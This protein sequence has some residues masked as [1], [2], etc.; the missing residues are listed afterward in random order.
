[1]RNIVLPQDLNFAAQVIVWTFHELVF[2]RLLVAV[3][4]LPLDLLAAFVVT[5]NDFIET[6]L[7]MR[8]KVL[9][10]DDGRAFLVR[11]INPPVGADH[12]V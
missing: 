6:S 8:V 1:M 2:T 12:L 9:I 4:V 5:I 10:D 11:A 7:I 3:Q